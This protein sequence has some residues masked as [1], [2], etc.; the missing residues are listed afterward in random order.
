[1][2]ILERFCR[3]ASFD[4]QSSEESPSYPSTPGQFDFNRELEKE[5]REIGFQDVR[6]D[7]YGV[8][9]ATVPANRP[10]VP[11]MAWLA[12]V[13]TSPE[14][15]GHGVKPQIHEKYDG[16][17]IV[18][19]GSGEILSPKDFPELKDV[20]GHTVITSDGT[21]LLGTDC[22]AGLTAIIEAAERL[23]KDNSL[24]HGE[25]R[26]CFSVDEEVG[27]GTEHLDPSRLN[28]DVA[29]TLDGGALG[30]VDSE[31]F[32]ADLA[33]V[34]ITGIN[35]HPAH[36]KD[37]MVNAIRIG[38]E[39]ISRMPRVSLSPETSD[40]RQGFL[41]PYSFEGGVDKTE[42]KIILRDFET[43]LLSVKKDILDS[44]AVAL[45]A[46]YPKATIE[47]NVRRQYRNMRDGLVKEPR[48]IPYA[49]EAWRRSGIEPRRTIIRGGT[50]GSGLTEMGLPTPNLSS[51]QH[52]I[53]SLNEWTSVEEMEKVT[54]VLLNLAAIWTEAP[55]LETIRE[56]PLDEG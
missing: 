9:T 32:S 11:V 26:I 24:P 10:N 37:H 13:D 14:T 48:A 18:L 35:T 20:I 52:N 5:L 22:K 17:D 21:T 3:Y 34:T 44:I 50:D 46:E 8:L 25:I 12:H 40:K 38:A 51:A 47:V 36:G 33:T 29:Y 49:L 27:R 23:L 42:I 30:M 28:A 6:L 1:M 55:G 53:H 4:T 16:G 19:P 43:E 31:T 7:E 15:S 54:E 2:S 45:R 56:A 41:H 39:F